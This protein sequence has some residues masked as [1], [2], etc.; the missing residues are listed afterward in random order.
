MGK[1]ICKF[2]GVPEEIG[3]QEDLDMRVC[4]RRAKW[5]SKKYNTRK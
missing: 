1:M 3:H 4:R 2:D 5:I